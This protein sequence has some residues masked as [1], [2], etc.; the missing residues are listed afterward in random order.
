MNP[1]LERKLAAQLGVPLRRATATRGSEIN[2]TYDVELEDG[3]VVF[4]KTHGGALPGLYACEAEGLTWLRAA[5]ALRVP[6]VLAS[7]EADMQGPGYLVLE[8]IEQGRPAPDY[9]EQLGT[10]LAAL[11]R[12]GAAQFGL[13]HD[14]Y[15]ATLPQDNRTLGTETWGE[16]YAM[17]RI[18]PQLE[19]A[20]RAGRIPSALQQQLERLLGRIPELVGPEEAPARLHGDLWGGNVI[21]DELG[22]P[23]LID[24]AVY[25]GSREIDLAMMRLFGGF[26]E[27]VFAAYEASYPLPEG[28]RERTSLY[29][30]YPLLVHVNLFGS[31]YVSQLERCVAH[32]A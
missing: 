13:A 3:R 15:L 26:S 28:H 32:W 25:G 29:Q 2:D 6:D 17:R 5:H 30:L 20:L 1:S 19:R 12:A 31:S 21:C 4:V 7:A 22:S 11:H 8:R 18:A 9:D 14:N 10:G 27:S 23:V 16:F 24:P